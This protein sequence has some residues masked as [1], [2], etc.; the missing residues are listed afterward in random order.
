MYKKVFLN[1]E[2][3]SF[4]GYIINCQEFLFSALIIVIL[5]Y[6][7]IAS[8][9]YDVE[10]LPSLVDNE[11]DD[12][13]NQDSV[14]SINSLNHLSTQK[15]ICKFINEFNKII[16][17][18]YELSSA[19][20]FHERL[21][22]LL[23]ELFLLDSINFSHQFLFLIYRKI[24]A[25]KINGLNIWHLQEFSKTMLYKLKIPKYILI[26]CY[27]EIIKLDDSIISKEEKDFFKVEKNRLQVI[28][29]RE[30]EM[31]FE[32]IKLNLFRALDKMKLALEVLIFLC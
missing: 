8:I 18:S 10:F 30:R 12:Y 28:I 21:L 2:N 16:R 13:N 9:F 27:S 31:L 22:Q 24:L 1:I 14:N 19:Q 20:I 26:K 32:N 11:I 25:S 23:S 15:H 5:I 17:D 3:F 7:G 6:F 29:N 4:N